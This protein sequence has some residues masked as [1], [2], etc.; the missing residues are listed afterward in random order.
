VRVRAR[1]YAVLRQGLPPK[2]E[3]CLVINLSP[4]QVRPAAARAQPC[5]RRRVDALGARG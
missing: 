2:L 3:Y 4:L 1:R 5:A